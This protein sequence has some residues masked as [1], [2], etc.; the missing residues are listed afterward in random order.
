MRDSFCKFLKQFRFRVWI[1]LREK[2][3]YLVTLS[4]WILFLNFSTILEA[5]KADSFFTLLHLV[6]FKICRS[7]VTFKIVRGKSHSVQ[8]EMI[9]SW[10]KTI[11][12]IFFP[13]ANWRT[14]TTLTSIVSSTNIYQTKQFTSSPTNVQ[15]E[16]AAK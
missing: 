14:F 7:Y 15:V 11:S 4:I 8:P 13:S 1:S 10:C 16:S 6:I 2:K 3:H 5:L 12:P 9:A